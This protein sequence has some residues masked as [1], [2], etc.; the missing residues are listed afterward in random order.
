MLR[1]AHLT[2]GILSVVV[3]SSLLVVF[4]RRWC[5][6]RRSEITTTAASP[7]RSNSFQARISKLHQTSLIHQLDTSDIK[8]RGNIKNYSISR[9]ATTGGFPSKPG[10]FIW[11][12][13]PALVTEAVDNGWTRFGFALHEPAPLV[14]GTSPGSVLLGLCTTAGSED[15]GVVITWEVSNGSVDF[16]QTIKFNQSFKE[17]VNAVKPLMV[18]RGALPLPGPQL[19]SSAFPQEAYFEITI[20]EI[21]QR[22]HGEGGDVSCELVE[23]EKTKLFK[24][25]GLKLVQ[26]REWDG[27]NEEAVLSLGLATG[28]SLGAAGETRLPGKFPASIGFQ[29]NGSIYLDGMKLVCESEKHE[30]AKENKVVG[31][32]YDPRKKKVYFTVNSHLVHVINCKAD[33]FGTPLYP[34]LASNT[35]AT[36]LVNLG[37]SPF[38]YGPANAQRTSNPC[39]GAVAGLE[40]SKELFSIGRI[41]SHYLSNFFINR[42]NSDEIASGRTTVGNSHRRKLDYDEESDADLFE[43]TLER[44]G[45]LNPTK[46]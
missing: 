26:R 33:E 44:S 20:L 25:Q 45:K 40:D 36:V 6:L 27:E 39:A 15:P 16:T 17:T 9:S 31:C 28:G 24:S 23:G 29:S 5:C 41:D 32:G 34:T 18:L 14:T 13:H 12:D 22:R 7:I 43:I 21:T 38:Y 8:R 30:W 2:A 42:G 1:W 19:V 35:E 37:Q 10:L 3:L 11:T 46:L 4:L